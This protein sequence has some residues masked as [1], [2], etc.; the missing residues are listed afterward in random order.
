MNLL[1]SFADNEVAEMRFVVKKFRSVAFNCTFIISHLCFSLSLEVKM[2]V[3]LSAQFITC[4]GRVLYQ[5]IEFRPYIYREVNLENKGTSV[6]VP[7]Q[8]FYRNLS[9][10][11]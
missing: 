4:V 9:H 3:S 8:W 10:D 7:A 1:T 6:R 11:A 2:F 5:C